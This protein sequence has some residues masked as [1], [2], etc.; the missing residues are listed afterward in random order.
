[1]SSCKNDLNSLEE[2]VPKK[3]EQLSGKREQE[4]LDTLKDEVKEVV[5][6]V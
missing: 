6:R 4:K 5:A 1:M 2:Y 3:V